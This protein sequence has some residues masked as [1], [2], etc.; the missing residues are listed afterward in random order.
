MAYGLQTDDEER[1][2]PIASPIEDTSVTG[3]ALVYGERK[4]ATAAAKPPEQGDFRRGMGVAVDQGKQAVYGVKAFVGDLIGSESIKESGLKEYNRVSE[5]IGARSKPSDSFT[6]AWASDDKGDLI[7]WLQYGAGYVLAQA[8]MALGTAAVGAV[9]GGAAAATG[10]GAGVVGALAKG[11]MQTGVKKVVGDMVKKRAAAGL[12][13]EAAVAKVFRDLGA[14]AALTSFNLSQELGHIYPEAIHEAEKTGDDVSLLRVFSASVLAAGVETLTDVVNLK[15]LGKAVSGKGTGDAGMLQRIATEAFA[16]GLREGGTELVQTGIERWGASQE[17]TS[18]EAMKDYVDSVALGVLGGAGFGAAK[19]AITKTEDPTAVPAPAPAAPPVAAPAPQPTLGG[20]ILVTPELREKYAD[21]LAAR[22]ILNDTPEGDAAIK[23]LEA[24]ERATGVIRSRYAA[25]EREARRK[26]VEAAFGD[27]ATSG[28][29]VGVMGADTILQRGAVTPNEADRTVTVDDPNAR[30]TLPSTN[31]YENSGKTE[32]VSGEDIVARQENWEAVPSFDIPANSGLP[33]GM[34]QD[35]GGRPAVRNYFVSGNQANALVD[36]L[37]KNYEG[38]Q[39]RARKAKRSKDAGGG[40]YYFVE[41]RPDAGFQWPLKARITGAPSPKLEGNDP[42]VIDAEAPAA[43]PV[44][45]ARA[46]LPPPITRPAPTPQG[47]QAITGPAGTTTEAP[48]EAPVAAAPVEPAKPAEPTAKPAEPTVA[49]AAPTAA[50]A[51]AKPKATRKRKVAEVQ[52]DP[53]DVEWRRT[54]DADRRALISR[55]FPNLNKPDGGLTLF[56][57]SLAKRSWENLGA[58]S[59]KRLANV[60]AG[61]DPED[62]GNAAPA[63]TPAPAPAPAVKKAPDAKPATPQQAAVAAVRDRLRKRTKDPGYLLDVVDEP[64]SPALQAAKEVAER[65]FGRKIT[66]VK[67]AGNRLFNGMLTTEGELMIDVD[68]ARPPLAVLG[69]ELLHAMR[70]ENPALYDQFIRDLVA[71]SRDL[72]SRKADLDEAYK[73]KGMKALTKDVFLEEFGADVVGDFFTDPKFWQG[74]AKRNQTLFQQVADFVL[75]FLRTLQDAMGVQAGFR[76]FRTDQLLVDVGK[77]RKQVIAAIGEYAQSREAQPPAQADLF[78]VRRTQAAKAVEDLFA[79]PIK[80]SKAGLSMTWIVTNPTE[81]RDILKLPAMRDQRWITKREF[82]NALDA[83]RKGKVERNDFSRAAVNKLA[84]ALAEE[85]AWYANYSPDSGID[86]YGVKFQRAIDKLSEVIPSLKSRDGRG[87]FTALLAITSDGTEVSE[88]LGYAI[89][90]YQAFERGKKLGESTPGFGKYESVYQKNAEVLDDLIEDRGLLGTVN[91]LLEPHKVSSLKQQVAELGIKSITS[92]Y[93][94]DA[95]L[96]R[97]AVF[98]GPKLGAFYA[99]LMGETGYLTMDRWWTR[100]INRYRGYLTPQPTQSSLDALRELMGKPR[101]SDEKV[102]DLAEAIARERQRKYKA[103]Q[104]R[105]EFYVASKLET[106]ATTVYKNARSELNDSPQGPADRAFNIKVAKAA[107][108]M[109]AERGINAAIADIQA[110]IWY[111]E[112]ELFA[113]I[114]V[115]GPDRISYEEAANR[116]VRERGRPAARDD[117]AAQ[118][119]AAAPAGAQVDLFSLDRNGGGR[120]ADAGTSP[121]PGS[122]R[123]EG[124]TGPDPRLVEVAERYARAN[125]IALRRQAEYVQVD[126]ERAQRIAAAYDAMEHNP[127]DPQVLRAYQNLIR[128]TRAQYDAL[129]DAGYSFW[130]IDPDRD[131]YKSPWDA[132]RDL[133]KTQT[134]GVFPT[135]AGFGSGA[136]A[137]DVADNPMLADTGLRWAYGSPNGELR[138][139]LANDLFRAV[140]DAFGHGLEG[141]GFRAQGEENAWQAHAR[142]FTGS[143]VA[144]ITTET[145]GQNSWLNYGPYGERNRTAKVEDTVFADQKTGLMPSWTWTEGRAGDMDDMLSVDRGESVKA[146]P[147]VNLRRLAGLLGPQLYGDMKEMPKVAVKEMFQNAFDAAKGAIGKKPGEQARIAVAINT[148]QGR[149]TVADNGTGMTTQIL[150]GPF[151]QIAGTNKEGD[152]SSGGFGIAKMQFLFGSKEL[153]VFTMRDGVLSVLRS[154]GAQLME[155]MDNPTARPDIQVYRG[156][157]AMRMFKDKALKAW[158]DAGIYRSMDR[159]EIGRMTSGTVVTVSVPDSYEDPSTGATEKIETPWGT[160]SYPVLKESPLF[161]DIK[162][163]VGFDGSSYSGIEMGNDFPI[164]D[165]TRLFDVKFAWGS[166]QIYSSKEPIEV[167]PWG[168]SNASYLSNGLWQFSA[169]MK[170]G[171]SLI[172]RKFFVNI[173]SKVK[174]EQAGY[175]F[176]LNRQGLTDQAAKDFAVVHQ[177]L[178]MLYQRDTLGDSV[179]E[180]SNVAYILPDGTTEEVKGLTA[181]KL[182]SGITNAAAGKGKVEVKDGQLIVNGKAVPVLSAD[183]M[184]ASKVAIENYVVPDGTVDVNRPLTHDNLMIPENVLELAESGRQ[185]NQWRESDKKEAAAMQRVLFSDWARQRFGKRFDQMNYKFADAFLRLRNLVVDLY[186]DDA[187]AADWVKNARRSATGVGYDQNYRGV[188]AVIPFRQMLINP[189]A[190]VRTDPERGSMGMYVTMVHEIAHEKVRQHGVSFEAQMQL[191]L[192][193]LMFDQDAAQLRADLRATF[194]EYQDIIPTLNKALIYA[195]ENSLGQPAGR[196]VQSESDLKRADA[197]LGRGGLDAGNDGGLGPVGERTAGVPGG[198]VQ[199]PLDP[200]GEQFD[201]G[202]PEEDRLSI[203]RPGWD[204]ATTAALNDPFTGPPAQTIRQRLAGLRT[205]FLRRLTSQV[206]DP[207]VGL[208]SL[209]E[210]LYMRARLTNGTD[211]GLDAL[212]QHGQVYSNG[213]ALDVKPN[214]KGLVDALKPLGSEVEDF[215]RWVALNRAAKLKREDRE[216]FFTDESIRLKDKF[217]EGDMA[218][219]Q[220]RAAVYRQAL[221]DMNALNRSVLDLA[222]QNGL[223]DQAGHARY[224]N[225]IWYVPF[226]RVAEEREGDVTAYGAAAGLSGQEFGKRLKGGT[227]RVDNLL[228]NLLRNW[229]GLLAASQRNGVA[230][231]TLE[232]AASMGVAKPVRQGTE[233]AVTVMVAGRAKAFA[234]QDPLLVDAL[235]SINTSALNHPILK[236]FG[237]FKRWLTGAVTMDPAFK[238]RNLIRDSIQS[239][240]LAELPY[241]PIANVANGMRA[242]RTDAKASA[243]AGGGLFHGHFVGEQGLAEKIERLARTGVNRNTVLTDPKDVA[244]K[245]LEWYSQKGDQLENANRM[246]LYSSMIA[247]GKTHLEAAYAAR[248]LMDF[249]LQGRSTAVRMLAMTLPFF[250]ARLQGLYKLGR[251]GIAPT[252]LTVMGRGD[253]GDRAKAARFATM[254]GAVTLAGLLLYLAYKDDEEFQKRE[255]WDRDGFWWFRVGDVG[256]RIPKPFELGAIGTIAERA[257]EQLVDEDVGGQVFAKSM[258]DMLVNTFAFDPIPQAIRPL[259]NLSANRDSFTDRPIESAGM[260]NLSKVERWGVGTTETA[261]ALSEANAA[262]AGLFGPLGKDKVL[263]PAQI[264]YLA[265]GYFGWLGSTVMQTTGQ[266]MRWGDNINYPAARLE[267]YPLVGAFARELPSAQSRYL[268]EFYDSA[269]LIRQQYQDI[270]HY[271]RLG[272]LDEAVKLAGERREAVVLNPIYTKAS[273]EISN[274]NSQMRRIEV[275]ATMGSDEKRQMLNLLSERKAEI[276]ARVEA[277]RREVRSRLEQ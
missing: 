161:E 212:M 207:F 237:A 273:R 255:A 167:S 113:S 92:D 116:W 274:L 111:Y 208:K 96:P 159:E 39:A 87:L 203:A 124:A 209:D 112:K 89:D 192:G 106:L 215:F 100:T 46:N 270:K 144:A 70:R 261:K 48:T 25:E 47:T 138:P 190:T 58:G 50:P 197:I 134:M 26:E 22:G 56:G 178:A 198:A 219:G 180:I 57:E 3:R 242:M 2:T 156:D 18:P 252:I 137:L 4:R 249:S 246:A 141:A 16:G 24:T 1:N 130:F 118:P 231:D 80:P 148:E 139:V 72:S 176:Q 37:T 206:V 95:I 265:R 15:G 149:I 53:P 33:A 64:G 244:A 79:E 226:Y 62:D 235:L 14:G 19:G 68:S 196:N 73:A 94:D 241:N 102:I 193:D 179:K 85:V 263:S 32:A 61:R 107:Q 150:G 82:G 49:P 140:H 260:Q 67:Q 164:D 204:A 194:T 142:L 152:R 55:A 199:G 182:E 271:Q 66:F 195:A 254:A 175:P 200:G 114:G 264:D 151:L 8:G 184:K 145:R 41:I 13:T 245:V 84:R 20:G 253:E 201:G 188:N 81:A 248:D 225:D 77:A 108:S 135:D 35:N 236:V 276:A 136:T 250:N 59:K 234:V 78:S 181:P 52:D 165:Y 213:G 174:P 166:A 160:Y 120:G 29:G 122:P 65:V 12:T 76:P 88:N 221:A 143:A 269:N 187:S 268:T 86:W 172:P 11:G 163:T 275:D 45:G 131:P 93:P 162:V 227:D 216:N 6:D 44:Y 238:V 240:S 90:M 63:P 42:N 258:K 169:G 173:A 36:Y 267:D 99:N 125:G 186:E 17:L 28:V 69:H 31:W 21:D 54:L 257:M 105:G 30:A 83:W 74:L 34:V 71:N 168:G 153:E 262:V 126:E 7:D 132:M 232:Q 189:A 155:A 158:E 266:L 123:I 214:T 91:Y 218:N 103:A 223:I 170:S 247:N 202:L 23:A 277:M 51:A 205:D 171:D 121:L 38:V 243:L 129:A 229:G 272:Q 101:T 60:M 233:G 75:D 230:R 115:R 117:R 109:L 217:I 239:I 251:D 97:A 104:D 147:G 220:A 228:Q 10:L 43:P 27:T 9:G 185:F 127:R 133:R 224:T 110:T 183:D 119:R 157:E 154:T 40:S 128:Q 191:L 146:N 177:Y 222:L 5:E 259:L 210:R 256:Y 211:G 98:L